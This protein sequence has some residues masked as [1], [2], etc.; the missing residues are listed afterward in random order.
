MGEICVE[1]RMLNGYGYDL[2]DIIQN[3]IEEWA[4]EICAEYE[5]YPSELSYED[6]Y[7][8]ATGFNRLFR[9]KINAPGH[10]NDLCHELD[11]ATKE[12]EKAARNAFNIKGAAAEALVHHVRS[13]SDFDASE[14]QDIPKD[15]KGLMMAIASGKISA[16]DAK[17]RLKFLVEQKMTKEA[18]KKIEKK[19]NKKFKKM[20]AKQITK[21]AV[22]IGAKAAG[23]A[24]CKKIPGV[25]AVVG[26]GYGISEICQGNYANAGLEMG[27]GFASCVPGPGTAISCALDVAGASKEIIEACLEWTKMMEEIDRICPA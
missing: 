26:M 22:K 2:T 1:Y 9:I 16:N 10:F 11:Y 18:R 12:W 24:A 23:K 21:I 19:M 25:G 13:C 20:V 14:W 3:G 4:F 27:S 6:G 5:G 7:I 17:G 8:G 15:I